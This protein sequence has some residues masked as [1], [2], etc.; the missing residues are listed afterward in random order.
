[1][2][3]I[4]LLVVL[5]SCMASLE[6]EHC[7]KLSLSNFDYVPLLE[8]DYCRNDYV[9]ESML[10]DISFKYISHAQNPK[11]NPCYRDPKHND[12]LNFSMQICSE[13]VQNAC[14]PSYVRQMLKPNDNSSQDSKLKEQLKEL[15]SEASEIQIS[16]RTEV[17]KQKQKFLNIIDKLDE[18]QDKYY[19]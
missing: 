5:T 9:C 17:T 1:M 3:L 19:E 11:L 4:L 18:I 7:L 16:L 12:C 14:A 15:D 6:C 13:L 10:R 8:N 2:K